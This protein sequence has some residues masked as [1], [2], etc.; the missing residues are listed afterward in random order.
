MTNSIIKTLAY[1]DIFDTPLTREEL[2]RWAWESPIGNFTEFIKNLDALSAQKTISGK[3]GFYFLPGRTEII[4]RRERAVSIVEKKMRIA[5]RAAR[6]LR[7][8]PFVAAVFVCNTVALGGVKKSS[9][10]DV[11]IIIKA[12]RLWLARLLTAFVLS[13]VGLRRNRKKITNK[14]CLSFYATDDTLNL[15]PIKIAPN[16]IYLIY[17]LDN[18]IPIYDP[19]NLH[20][21]I[22]EANGWA[23]KYLPH[24]FLPY[25][26]LPRWRADDT[27]LSRLWRGFW[28]R[29][30]AGVYGGLLET[31]ARAA[32]KT[33]M[34]L[35]FARAQNHGGPNVIITDSMLKFHENDRREYFK[36]MWEEKVNDIKTNLIISPPTRGS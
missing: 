10:I 16:D 5:R 13:M 9:D 23:K 17:W 2:Y 14:I 4:A 36:K 22:M 12:S 33:K 8:V 19:T 18:L 34:K 20:K 30:W 31:Q 15:E 3:D 11:F 27:R 1:F 26:T 25:R 7:W 21:K 6:K 24:A 32:Q 35:N 28:E 29:A